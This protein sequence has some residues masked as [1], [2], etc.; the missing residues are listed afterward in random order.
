MANMQNALG[1]LQNFDTNLHRVF[2]VLVNELIL[3]HLQPKVEAD[4]NLGN[5]SIQFS[6]TP[7][8]EEELLNLLSLQK[9]DLAIDVGKVRESSF[10][11]QAIYED[12]MVMVARKNHSR[13]KNVV[14]EADYYR[15]KHITI[16]MRRANLYAMDYFTKQSL[17]KRLISSECDS[18]LSMVTLV[19]DTDCLGCTSKSLADKYAPLF[20][21]N[22]FALPFDTYPVLQNMIWHKRTQNNPAYKWLR[23]KI[24]S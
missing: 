5:V 23:S 22:I 12:K 4:A 18:L 6:M 3:M 7:S 19:A 1:N 8:N 16:K 11:L 14:S 2:H 24:E 9:S 20:G 17:G 13:I 10:Q 15:E 21:L